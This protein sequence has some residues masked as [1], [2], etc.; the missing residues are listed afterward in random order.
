MADDHTNTIDTTGAVAVGGSATGNIET[1][2]DRDWFAVELEAGR[3]YR[4]DLKGSPTGD[5]TLSDTFLRR[6]LDADG[7]KSVGDGAHATYNDDFGGTRNSQVTFTAKTSGTYYVETSGDRNETGTYTLSVTDVTPAAVPD[8]PAVVDPPAVVSDPDG[9]RAGAQDLGDITALAGARFPRG[10][11]DG[12]DDALDYYRF[13]LTEAKAVGLGLRRQDAN[14]DLYLEDAEGNVLHGSTAAG[15]AN[16]WVSATVLAGTYY[17]RVEAKEAGTNAHVF[18]YGVSEA[19]ADEVARLQA[20]HAGPPT[21]VSEPEGSD[22]SA[23]ASTSGRVLAGE[24]VTGNIAGAGDVD[25]FAV[26]MQAGTTYRLDLLGSD[27]GQGTLADPY[28]RGVHDSQG[29]R[30]PGTENGDGGEGRNARVVFTPE[31]GGTHYIAAGGDGSRTGTYRLAVTPAVWEV[32]VAD[33]Q[34]HET[35][36]TI[37]F[38]VTLDWAPLSPVTVGYE[39]VDGTALAGEDYEAKSGTLTFAEGE[40]EQWVDVTLVDD[41]EEDSGETFGLRLTEATGAVLGDAEGTG[42]ILNA[43]T[44]VSVSEPS[45][46]DFAADTTT[47][48]RVVV[49]ESVTGEITAAGDVDWFA[50]EMQL[51]MTYRIDLLGSGLKQGTLADPYLRGVHDSEANLLADSQNNDRHVWFYRSSRVDFTPEADGTYYVAAGANGDQTGTY[52]LSVTGYA[53]DHAASRN[54]TGTVAVDGSAN[55]EL[56]V[57]GD[58]DWFAVELEAG[59]TYRIDLEGKD[60][61]QG[62]LDGPWL[63]GVHDAEGNLLPDTENGGG[64]GRSARVIYTPEESGTYY[65]ATGA[66]GSQTGTYRVSVTDATDDYTADTSTTGAVA[67]GGTTNGEVELAGDR[68]WFAVE[69]EAGRAYRFELEGTDTGHGTLSDP[70]LHGIHDSHGNRLPGTTDDDG[71]DGRNSRVDFT[72]EADGTYYVSAGA[73]GPR[74]IGTYRLAVEAHPW[75]LGISDVE[76]EESSKEMHFRVVLSYASPTTVTVNFETEDGTAVAGADYEAVSGT[77]RFAPGETEKRVR[78]RLYDDFVDDSGETLTLRLSDAA[79]AALVDAEAVGTILN[80]DEDPVQVR[81]SAVSVMVGSSTKGKIGTKGEVD[82]FAV[83]LEADTLYRIDL[84]GTH[85]EAGTLRDPELWGIHDMHGNLIPDTT[86]DDGGVFWN[87]RVLFTPVEAGTYYVAAAGRH[88]GTYALSVREFFD[89]DDYLASRDTTGTVSVGSSTTGDIEVTGDVDWFAVDLEADKTYRI[90]LQGAHHDH[91][92]IKDSTLRGIYENS[93]ALIAGTT[94]DR[95]G[96]GFYDNRLDFTPTESGT[97]FVAAGTADTERDV[98]F[99]E[100]TYRLSVTDITDGVPDDFAATTETTGTVAVGGSATGEVEFEGDRDWFA[101]TLEA[102]KTYRIDL[103]GRWSGDGN[104]WRAFLHGVHDAVGDLISGTTE[105]EE[106]ARNYQHNSR[107]EFTPTEAG[108]YYVA[109]GA[110]SNAR[111]HWEGTYT[112]SV[113]ED[114]M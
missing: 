9:A 88:T 19:D 8:E 61:G 47:T 78:V 101:V 102:G 42:T 12:T 5:G 28:L 13:T 41:T 51:G 18:R 98:T 103:E 62:T 46:T 4:L 36:G 54:T 2:Q 11:V 74:D 35:D 6:I 112:L 104:L 44:P 92:T 86:N 97:Y 48:G 39:T 52:R 66:A 63:E 23:D 53:D 105:N 32:D 72:P 17:V 15:T 14:A 80:I 85:T 82:W 33:A 96:S 57:A 94:A 30:L 22:F 107:V 90:D 111:A 70:H 67:V 109:A 71:G 55:G 25:W 26:E 43:E 77:F 100:G 50:V 21:S 37:R 1:A 38:R 20:Q 3:T 106:E 84:E 56:E 40:T 110:L 68:D 34:A 31:A 114:S 81:A 58:R 64:E 16:E 45:G 7:D 29:N 75:E 83:E 73:G 24:S 10:E 59:K 99:T 76:A 27:P 91:G 113:V 93:G 49:G 79:G 60:T 95:G 65:I 69:L 89:D 108:T 87:S